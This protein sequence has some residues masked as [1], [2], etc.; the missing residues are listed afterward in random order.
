MNTSCVNFTEL[1]FTSERELRRYL[2]NVEA[3]WTPELMRELAGL[4][5]QRKS[6]TRIWNHNDQF[7]LG[8]LWEYASPKAFKECQRV[9][10]RSILPHAHKFEMVARS[11]R[12]I[13]ILD[14][15][16]DQQEFTKSAEP[17]LGT[18]D[19]KDLSEQE[20]GKPSGSSE[21]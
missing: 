7:K 1:R 3:I 10:T 9:I 15:R 8:I 5:L 16:G 12:G 14:W 13:P 6:I 4:G 18:V 17:S 2:E 20:L 19:A 11:F 21:G